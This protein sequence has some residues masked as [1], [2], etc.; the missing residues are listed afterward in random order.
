MTLG[1]LR[2]VFS[3]GMVDCRRNH[4]RTIAPR[5]SDELGDRVGNGTGA[6]E[7][8]E[9][10]KD[11]GDKEREVRRRRIKGRASEVRTV[12]AIVRALLGGWWCG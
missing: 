4:V 8:E 9:K 11:V 2:V 12:D 10:E 7:G 3:L 1:V 6:G 5:L